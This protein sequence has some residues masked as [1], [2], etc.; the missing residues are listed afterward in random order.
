MNQNFVLILSFVTVLFLSGCAKNVADYNTAVNSTKKVKQKVPK[1]FQQTDEVAN[2]VLK[3]GWVSSFNDKTLDKLVS[4]ALKNNPDIKVAQ[5]KVE[6]SKALVGLSESDSKATVGFSGSYKDK[7]YKKEPEAKGE[8]IVSWQADVWG[9][10]ENSIRSSIEGQKASQADYAYAQQLLVASVCK[11]WFNVNATKIYLMYANELVRV[12]K[13]LFQL[14]Q[15][16]YKIGHGTI[17]DVNQSKVNYENTK[18]AQSQSLLALENAKRSLE[19]LLG[20]YPN[21]SIK[22]LNT[23]V[24]VPS[25]FPVG[26]PAQ[27]LER[28]PDLIAAQSRVAE[29]FYAQKEAELLHLPSLNFSLSAGASSINDFITKL[30]AGIFAP[31]Y[32]GGA[33]ESQVKL[34]SAQQKEAIASYASTALQ[35]FK[36]VEQSMSTEKYFTQQKTFLSTAVSHNK[37]SYQLTQKRYEIGQGTLL[38]VLEKERELIASQIAELNIHLG[39]LQNR[40]DLYLALGGDFK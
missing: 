36:D 35:A 7:S 39:L 30:T 4:E 2:L 11:A 37:D 8:F 22:S 14:K 15:K 27:L 18:Q 17:Q 25:K 21:S 33:I 29:A 5:S 31:L 23:L 13:E 24:A 34:A 9:R 32:T 19:V 12:N 38:N 10:I 40:V 20:R 1:T 6:Q 16:S 3:D 26:V 28:R